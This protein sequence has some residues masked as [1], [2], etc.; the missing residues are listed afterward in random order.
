MMKRF[1]SGIVAVVAVVLF[2]SCGGDD[3]TVVKDMEK[4]IISDDKDSYPENCQVYMRGE[5]VPFRCKFTDNMELGNYNIEIHNNFDHHSHGTV[6]G[7]CALY[8]KKKA[9]NPWI[10][11]Q[12]YEI[13]AGSQV[14]N[15]NINIPIPKDIDAGDYHFMVRVTDKSGWQEI[16]AVSI[17][18]N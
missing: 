11:N 6:A 14:F 17:K 13:P 2:A 4:P 9:E 1:F 12:S 10:Y 15:A 16:K 5:V 18:V 7:D 8:S 3:D